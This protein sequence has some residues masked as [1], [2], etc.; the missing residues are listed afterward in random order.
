MA[1]EDIRRAAQNNGVKLWEIAEQFGV[2]DTTFSKK[3]RHEFTSKEKNKSNGCNQ[4]DQKGAR[5]V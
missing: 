1:N 2:T 4:K 3:L 5:K